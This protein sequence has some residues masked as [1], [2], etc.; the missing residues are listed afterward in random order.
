MA[1]LE[2]PDS[3]YLN[4][5]IGWLGL[6]NRVE[7]RLELERISAGK[8]E[9]PDVLEV[10]WVIHAEAREW[11]EGLRVARLLVKKA[12]KRATGWL[13]QSYALRRASEGGLKAAWDALLPAVAKFPKEATIPYNLACYACQLG[14]MD[15]AKAWFDRAI[16]VGGKKSIKEMAL[17]DAD[18]EPLWPDILKL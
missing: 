18:L 3:F 12:P 1:A 5:A 4:A 11:S 13:H 14:R 15:E 7:A 2:P 17:A 16:H 9:H 8:R 10:D 6:Q